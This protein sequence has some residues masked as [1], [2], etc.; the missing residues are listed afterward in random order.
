[1]LFCYDGCTPY[2]FGW[3]DVFLKPLYQLHKR[4]V[5]HVLPDVLKWLWVSI[6]HTSKK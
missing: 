1:M 2:Q 4:R 5:Q 3:S 6:K